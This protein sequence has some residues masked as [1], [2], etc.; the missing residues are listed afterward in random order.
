MVTV[1]CVEP[2]LCVESDGHGMV[3]V[4]CV[5]PDGDGM[6]TVLCVEPDVS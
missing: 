1:L 6:V 3:I 2:V 4:L 5:E